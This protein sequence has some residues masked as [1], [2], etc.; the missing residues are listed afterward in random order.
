MN[1]ALTP[2]SRARR[3]RCAAVLARVVE[4]L[5]QRLSSKARR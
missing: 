4:K 2:C 3:A 5:E 1:T